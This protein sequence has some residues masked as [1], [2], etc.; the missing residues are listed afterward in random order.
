MMW[1]VFAILS[2][3][4]ESVLSMF[5][6]FFVYFGLQDIFLGLVCIVAIKGLLIDPLIA[7]EGAVSSMRLR[8]DAKRVYRSRYKK[9]DD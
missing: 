9:G 2:N 4:L 8:D 5:N 1:Q 6:R 3:T 7:R